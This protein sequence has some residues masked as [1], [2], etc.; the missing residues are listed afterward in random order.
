HSARSALYTFPLEVL[1][2]LQLITFTF[3]FRDPHD[4]ALFA[5][6]CEGRFDR[7]FSIPKAWLFSMA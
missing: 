2:V 5:S 3:S 1:S 7:L 4:Q 6:A